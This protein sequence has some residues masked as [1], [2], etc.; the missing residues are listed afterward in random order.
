VF[1]SEAFKDKLQEIFHNLSKNKLRTLLTGFSVSW[2]IFMLIILLGSGYGIE[3]GVRNSFSEDAVNSLWIRGGQTSRPYEGLKKGRPIRF[4][5]DDYDDLRQSIRGRENIAGRFYLGRDTTVR[6]RSIAGTFQVVGVHPQY[7]A[8]EMLKAMQGR[9]LNA[10][11]E[12]QQRKVAII[13]PKTKRELFPNGPVVGQY[14]LI[15]NISFQVVGVFND[16]GDEWQLDR[17]YIPISTMQHLFSRSDRVHNLAMTID[18]DAW[19]QP[20][21][22]EVAVRQRLAQR[23]RFHVDD[24]RAVFTYNTLVQF[25]KYMRLFANIR[26]FIWIIGIGSIVA[27]IVGVSNIML[28]TVKERTREIG[29]RKAIGAS[30]G[31]IIDLIVTE[32]I[33][34]TFFFGYLGLVAG[35]AVLEI[36]THVIQGVAYFRNPEVNLATAFGAVFLL[37]LSGTLAGIVPARRAAGIRPVE[38]LHDE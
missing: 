3:N 32:A 31:S 17:V 35:V 15:Q 7:A 2:G 11:D 27:G 9:L 8:I 13:G 36:M 4:R 1:A 16:A 28:I 10:S 20:E 26:L 25:Q 5:N 14:I 37:V 24:R 34:I 30:P 29:I 18:A 12:A 6:Y 22:V 33:I 38:A 19:H 23:H 21:A